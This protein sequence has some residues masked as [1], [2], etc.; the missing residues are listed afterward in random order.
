MIVFA[1]IVCYFAISS[2]GGMSHVY[3][4]VPA[5][6]VK[7]P[8]SIFSVGAY[9][10]FL[11][12]FSL[13]PGGLTNQMYYQRI[14]ACKELKEVKRSLWITALVCMLAYFWAVNVGLS[15]RTMNPTLGADR[16]MATGWLLTQLPTWLVAVFSGLVISAILSTIS[17]GVQSV[18][19]NLNRDIYR[20]T[21]PGSDSK[22]S[23]AFS[24][25]LSIIVMVV[26]VVLALAFPGVI[27]I[28]VTSY[29]FSAAGLLCPIFISYV[30]RKK[31]FITKN[32]IIAGMVVG[33]AACYASLSINTEIPYVIWGIVPSG[34]TMLVVSMIERSLKIKSAA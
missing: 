15:V 7:F 19:V 33:V 18:V 30:F 2:A 10:T 14:F 12:I 20:T 1:S 29:S 22:K 5:E 27:S 3:A 23:L 21:H 26:A 8:E 4:S 13:V 16:E 25:I 11:W 32:A 24:K 9:T 17:S 34:L 31:Q 28:L 6:I